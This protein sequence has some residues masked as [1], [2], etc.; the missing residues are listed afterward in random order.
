MPLLPSPY[1]VAA[2]ATTT[3]LSQG[4]GAGGDDARASRTDSQDAPVLM[5][6]GPAG[7]DAQARV[8]AS[9]GIASLRIDSIHVDDASCDCFLV[10]RLGPHWGR[11]ARRHPGGCASRRRQRLRRVA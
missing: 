1:E 9:V 7:S 4:G 2:S 8:A 10:L 11:S 6:G 3:P 5:T